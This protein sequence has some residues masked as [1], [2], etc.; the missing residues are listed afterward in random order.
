MADLKEQFQQY[1]L[2]S[3]VLI[4]SAKSNNKITFTHLQ[5]EINIRNAND[6]DVNNFSTTFSSVS[7]WLDLRQH[8]LKAMQ[9]V[10]TVDI[11][12]LNE[13]VTSFSKINVEVLTSLVKISK[14]IWDVSLFSFDGLPLAL[15]TLLSQL[16]ENRGIAHDLLS[17]SLKLTNEIIWK[18]DKSTTH[19]LTELQMNNFRCAVDII[20]MSFNE[21]SSFDNSF[22]LDG[23][24]S[25]VQQTV[26]ETL[27]ELNISVAV[28]DFLNHSVDLLTP[29]AEKTISCCN[30][31][32][33]VTMLAAALRLRRNASRENAFV[34]NR[35]SDLTTSFEIYVHSLGSIFRCKEMND[36]VN[37]DSQ[38]WDK[39]L[40]NTGYAR[41][42][43]ENLK[44]LNVITKKGEKSSVRISE[45]CDGVE[46]LLDKIFNDSPVGSS[47][48]TP[49]TAFSNII[50]IIVLNV[51]HRIAYG[52]Q[53]LLTG[54]EMESEV[55][56][57]R[58]VLTSLLISGTWESGIEIIEFFSARY[59]QLNIAPKR[60]NSNS[61][62]SSFKSPL[63][64]GGLSPLTAEK[65]SPFH[66]SRSLSSEDGYQSA[67]SAAP[68]S[69]SLMSTDEKK[70]LKSKMPSPAGRQDSI[71]A[72]L[73]RSLDRFKEK[74]K[75]D[76][77]LRLF[78]VFYALRIVTVNPL[79][80]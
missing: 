36:G 76:H 29:L 38:S 50:R 60:K 41:I 16:R 14:L 68:L 57:L 21:T 30:A 24:I 67:R 79:E 58:K 11:E 27:S 52:S 18:D 43:V 22:L 31:K 2:F 1:S 66:R 12:Y 46:L 44:A 40:R 42:L 13:A 78:P 28:G 61:D 80:R 59:N 54:V 17:N 70:T 7:L 8:L 9:S 55:V 4:F 63:S 73:S 6:N 23:F 37:T 10:V 26:F 49:N 51:R 33:V 72:E 25:S 39:K 77:A 48:S 75:H 69:P 64:T 65:K 3:L 56:L 47:V 62:Q 71:R 35:M 53:N 45:Y 74:L 34:F 5:N 19:S 32:K 20:A 15:G